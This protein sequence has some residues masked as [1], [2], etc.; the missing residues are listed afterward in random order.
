MG[1]REKSSSLTAALPAGR[2]A[3]FARPGLGILSVIRLV[4]SAEISKFVE[5]FCA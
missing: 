3:A 5:V 1:P 2:A 4:E